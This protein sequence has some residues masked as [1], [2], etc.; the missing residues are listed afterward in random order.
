VLQEKPELFNLVGKWDEDQNEADLLDRKR[1]MK[2]SDVQNLNIRLIKC[3]EGQ[4]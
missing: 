1:K 2:F 3:T 4:L